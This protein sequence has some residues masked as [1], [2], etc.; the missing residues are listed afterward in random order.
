MSPLYPSKDESK[1]KD[2]LESLLRCA[3]AERMCSEGHSQLHTLRR[4][5][6]DFVTWLKT[7]PQGDPL[8]RSGQRRLV[9]VQARASIMEPPGTAPCYQSWDGG[10]LPTML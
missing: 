3:R 1:A 6:R 5:G 4:P 8:T 7:A 9:S 10:T 2:R